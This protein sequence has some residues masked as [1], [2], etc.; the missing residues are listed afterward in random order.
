MNED[1]VADMGRRFDEGFQKL[2]R[3]LQDKNSSKEKSSSSGASQQ[4][5]SVLPDYVEHSFGGVPIPKAPARDVA[6]G[7]KMGDMSG[8][9]VTEFGDDAEDLLVVA[10]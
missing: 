7:P 8:L 10:S 5:T 4:R 6:P 1:R 2:E 3:L 9:V